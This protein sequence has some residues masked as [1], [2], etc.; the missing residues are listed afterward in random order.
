M[1]P[2]T[3][4]GQTSILI[5]VE[6]LD[7]AAQAA[8]QAA[9]S[10]A[11]QPTAYVPPPVPVP[12]IQQQPT[13]T[14]EQAMALLQ[15]FT[16]QGYFQGLGPQAT[17]AHDA[18][19]IE[20][21]LLNTG[22]A[23]MKQQQ[24]QQ[25]HQLQHQQQVQQQQQQNEENG[26]AASNNFARP[27]LH[28]TQSAFSPF[29]PDPENHYESSRRDSY[30]RVEN[31]PQANK[32]FTPGFF[33]LNQAQDLKVNTGANAG[34][35]GSNKVSPTANRTANGGLYGFSESSDPPAPLNRAP[36]RTE[37]PI[38]RPSSGNKA[39]VE[40]QD[41]AITDLNGTLASLELDRPWKSPA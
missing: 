21:A 25:Q 2:C 34:T 19:D 16:Q 30:S 31:L 26:S 1:C 32:A 27:D 6:L 7:K 10:A 20:N 17:P 37:A 38:S 3:T 22:F 13:L 36:G 39:Q 29:S 4:D 35:P 41:D 33:S 40:A 24:H 8:A 28:R 5:V 12:L 15:K 11:L 14:Q 23:N 9:Q 18:S